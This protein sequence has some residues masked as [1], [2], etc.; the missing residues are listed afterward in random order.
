MDRF[1]EL[2]ARV[3]AAEKLAQKVCYR[4]GLDFPI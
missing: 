2:E 4:A 3:V 1:A